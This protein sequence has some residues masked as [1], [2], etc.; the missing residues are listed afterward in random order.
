MERVD[1]LTRENTHGGLAVTSG[2]MYAYPPHAHTYCEMTLYEPFDGAITVNDQCV[3]MCAGHSVILMTP[4]DVHRIAVTDS[5]GARFIKIAFDEESVAASLPAAPLIMQ[6]RAM[7][8]R[9]RLRGRIPCRRGKGA[10]CVSAISFRR[11]FVGH[12]RDDAFLSD[13]AAP[14]PC[15]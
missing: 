8:E 6:R 14:A 5:Q 3:D 13:R 11:V 9:P 12:G 7:A 4:L 10:Q 15:R 2:E 1:C